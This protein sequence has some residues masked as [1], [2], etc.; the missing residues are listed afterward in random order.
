MDK[1]RT[2]CPSC[3]CYMSHH[4]TIQDWSKCGV[5]SYQEDSKGENELTKELDKRG[6][7]EKAK[8]Y[9]IKNWR[10]YYDSND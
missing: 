1:F 6:L 10:K 4:P 8:A 9:W 3:G 7:P 2:F 5:C